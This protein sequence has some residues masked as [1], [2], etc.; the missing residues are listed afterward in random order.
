MFS[1]TAKSPNGELMPLGETWTDKN[2][3]IWTR[4]TRK[5]VGD[6]MI[7]NSYNKNRKL[8]VIWKKNISNGL[9]GNTNAKGN[10]LSVKSRAKI[11]KALSGRVLTNNHK[12]NIREATVLYLKTVK[13]TRARYNKEACKFFDEL[14]KSKKWNGIHAENGGE[15]SV[16]GY[17]LDFYDKD[18]NKV[19]MAESSWLLDVA[20]KD[21][22]DITFHTT[23]EF[24][25]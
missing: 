8:D 14:N 11:S 4:K 1:V 23:S 20:I 24:K 5:K 19:F 21:Y 3:K 7:G 16:C 18:Q 2:P 12:K 22:P 6:R 13:K 9:S 15:Y 17:F 10:V 25:I